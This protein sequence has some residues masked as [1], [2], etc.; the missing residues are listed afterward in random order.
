M[1]DSSY[2]GKWMEKG[3]YLSFSLQK[4]MSNHANTIHY[5]IFQ[6]EG[7]AVRFSNLAVDV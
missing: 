7:L 3:E 4:F 5:G 2:V 6:M 1:N